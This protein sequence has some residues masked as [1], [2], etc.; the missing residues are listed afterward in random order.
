MIVAMVG[1][2]IR[3]LGG[4]NPFDTIVFNLMTYGN[5]ST[6]TIS[7]FDIE[8]QIRMDSLSRLV[9]KT[10]EVLNITFSRWFFL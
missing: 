2:E 9:I 10:L 4:A 8:S 5:P 3:Q 7:S 6:T 1:D